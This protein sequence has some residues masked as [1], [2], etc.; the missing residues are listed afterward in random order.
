MISRLLPHGDIILDLGGANCPLYKMGYPHRFKKLYVID[1]PPE[2]RHDLYK[3]ITIDLHCDDGEVFIQYGDMTELDDFPDESVD[4][5]WSGQ[6]IE[7]ISREAGERMCQAAFR[8]LKRGGAFCLD[9]PNRRLTEIHA[10]GTGLEF[11]NP[12]HRIE[13]DP[14]ELTQLLR[15]AG[16]EIKHSCGICDM[17]NTIATGEFCY[18]DFLFGKQITD[19]PSNGYLQFQYSVKP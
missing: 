5:V 1:L 13:Y 3:E 2:A 12:E 19:N 8:V 7:H 18:E 10:K 16:F 4:L 15:K 14:E 9:T 11:I 17:P 6:S